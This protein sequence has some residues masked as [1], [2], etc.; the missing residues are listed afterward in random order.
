M[1]RRGW[2]I[3]ALAVAML[4]V[5]LVSVLSVYGMLNVLQS[6]G[7]RVR[8]LEFSQTPATE[9]ETKQYTVGN[10]P[11][12]A[13][14]SSAGG[15]TV[16][17]GA[18]GVIEVET[19]KTAHGGDREAARTALADLAVDVSQQGD[20]LALR[21]VA[22][23]ELVVMGDRRAPDKVGFNIVVPA[24]TQVDLTA[25]QG[26][27]NLRGTRAAAEI[28]THFGETTVRDVAG[29]VQVDAQYGPLTVEAVKAG[30][31][32]VN[33]AT[34]F[35]DLTAGDIDARSIR[36]DTE[37]GPLSGR[38]LT[39]GD[40]L[41]AENKFGDISLADVRAGRLTAETNNGDLSIH[42]GTI[43]GLLTAATA[44]G[45]LMV[46]AVTAGR[47]ELDTRNGELRV[48]GSRGPLRLR[49]SFGAIRVAD[50]QDA[51]LD[52]ETTNGDI[53]VAAVLDPDQAST[54]ENSFGD[55]TLS[56]PA[57]SRL[58]VLLAA[59]FGEVSSALPVSVRGTTGESELEGTLN[60]GGP[61]LSAR[62]AN[63]DVRLE[64]LNTESGR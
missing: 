41:V 3:V 58:D 7:A 51:M 39:A 44:F 34:K 46:E 54:L 37:H 47:Y 13:V 35:G 52:V 33:L 25:D 38:D 30:E 14:A 61:L 4:A 57:D 40:E 2:A 5:C 9:R 6:S 10:R 55:I 18:D 28:T 19:V 50:A 42:R 26:D 22:P 27:V 48:D 36:L 20:S 11:D 59:D 63:G 12:L 43:V 62:T 64:R 23:E 21:F 53:D 56:I 60:G 29:P 32:E 24:D 1:T 17:V 45:D 15:I 49:N 8:I 16:T 31:G